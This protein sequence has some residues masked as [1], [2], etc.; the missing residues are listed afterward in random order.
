MLFHSQGSKNKMPL[1][2]FTLI[3]PDSFLVE[4]EVI[5]AEEAN[6]T[7]QFQSSSEG[8]GKLIIG[9]KNVYWLSENN[10]GIF[11]ISFWALLIFRRLDC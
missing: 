9:T 11:F 7:L 5:H 8:K 10:G 3:N 1:S 6:V 2:K 4:G